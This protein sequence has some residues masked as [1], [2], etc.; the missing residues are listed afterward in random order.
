MALNQSNK[1][2]CLNIILKLEKPFSLLIFKDISV[3]EELGKKMYVS[4]ILW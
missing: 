2:T 1:H 4:M 3:E